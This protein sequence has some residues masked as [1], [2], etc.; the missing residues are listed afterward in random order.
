MK[1]ATLCYVRNQGKTLMIHRIK[2]QD[3]MHAG[4]W[5]GLGGKLEPGESPEEC[6]IREVLEESGLRIR[7]PRLHGFL[8]FP[9][10]ANDEDWYAFVFSASEFEG[11]LIDSQ[12]GNLAWINDEQLFE[13]PLWEG[14]FI[15]LPWLNQDNFFSGKFVYQDGHL[16]NHNVFFHPPINQS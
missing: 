5:N 7:N 14:D 1:L 10:F 2:K 11:Q 13:L 4:K 15:F 6:V 9:G 8:T 16:V 12:E 3:D